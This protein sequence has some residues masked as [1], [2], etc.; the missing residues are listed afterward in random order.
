MIR[1]G[2]V[3]IPSRNER[4]FGRNGSACGVMITTLFSWEAIRVIYR[5]KSSDVFIWT[6]HYY[7]PHGIVEINCLPESGNRDDYNLVITTRCWC[8]AT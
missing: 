7:L 2:T 6:P 8:P 5:M 4:S 3:L 1:A